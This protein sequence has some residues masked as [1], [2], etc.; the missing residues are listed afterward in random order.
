MFVDAQTEAPRKGILESDAEI[1]AIENRTAAPSAATNLGKL[2][3]GV[4]KCMQLDN[5]NI[6]SRT[7]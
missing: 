4:F 5:L 1:V 6:W 7:R 2:L 3:K